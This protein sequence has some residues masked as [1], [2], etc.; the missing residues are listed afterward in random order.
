MS[1][2][3]RVASLLEKGEGVLVHCSDGWDRTAQVCATAQL[4]IDPYY[5]TLRGFAT[6]VEKEWCAF[7]HQFDKRSGHG[8][9]NHADD[10]RS[11]VFIQ[12]L[13]CIW[14]IW[15]QNPSAFEFN[16][17]F[18]S[19]LADSLY[20]CK[21]GTF[22]YDCERQRTEANSPAQTISV[23]AEAFR[24]EHINSGYRA[25][26]SRVSLAPR[27]LTRCL[28]IWPYHYRFN[29]EMNNWIKEVI[30]EVRKR[31]FTYEDGSFLPVKRAPTAEDYKYH[32]QLCV[33]LSI[34]LDICHFWYKF[35]ID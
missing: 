26:L 35:G 2:S 3:E 33:R 29:I 23:W 34:S 4:I 19:F 25:T 1:C 31:C 16:E 18:L 5:R 7:G 14:Q 32:V 6:L 22:L 12:W 27:C 11:P 24:K 15:N 10:Q 17:A 20:S 21:Y 30:E 13:D 9:S 8:N 28:G